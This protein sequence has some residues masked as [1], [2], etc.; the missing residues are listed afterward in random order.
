MDYLSYKSCIC[1]DTLR[2]GLLFV[3]R[4]LYLFPNLCPLWGVV[5]KDASF[6][7]APLESY[8]SSVCHDIIYL[9]LHK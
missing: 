6:M 5:E 7:T 1:H 9:I 2:M 4:G 3:K 8:S